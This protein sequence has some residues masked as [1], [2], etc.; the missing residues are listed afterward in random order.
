MATLCRLALNVS[1]WVIFHRSSPF[2]LPVGVCLAPKA[3]LAQTRF[4]VLGC[5]AF[6]GLD[7][8]EFLPDQ[9]LGG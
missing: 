5:R 8:L 4:A 3:T 2:C 9:A 1:K 7:L 6:Q